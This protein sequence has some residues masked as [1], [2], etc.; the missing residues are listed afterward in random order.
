MVPKYRHVGAV[1]GKGLMV[2]I[3]IIKNKETKEPGKEETNQLME[4]TR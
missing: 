3:D 4:L 2:G 1:Q